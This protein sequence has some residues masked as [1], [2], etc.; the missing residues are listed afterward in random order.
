MGKAAIVL[1]SNSD[2]TRNLVDFCSIYGADLVV[3]A[4]CSLFSLASY[5]L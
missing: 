5:R 4:G 1:L 3:D 2:E